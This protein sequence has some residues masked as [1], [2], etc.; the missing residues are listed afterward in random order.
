MIVLGRMRMTATRLKRNTAPKGGRDRGTRKAL[1]SFI[2][3]IIKGPWAN[4]IILET[5]YTIDWYPVEWVQPCG[6]VCMTRL[7]PL[8]L[9]GEWA[10]FLWIIINALE[11]SLSFK[12]PL[13]SCEMCSR[14]QE[15]CVC[16]WTSQSPVFQHSVIPSI[17]KQ[18]YGEKLTDSNI[19]KNMF[20]T[21]VFDML[22]NVQNC[23]NTSRW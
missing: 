13:M 6:C 9:L 10:V 15:S 4:W 8:R 21:K 12:A 17:P 14:Y 18:T 1:S 7:L 3:S 20:S 5:L 16:G 19:Q 23:K 11:Q 22:G 2:F